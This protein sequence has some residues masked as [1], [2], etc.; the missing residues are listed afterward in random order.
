MV[1]LSRHSTNLY[2][3]NCNSFLICMSYEDEKGRKYNRYKWSNCRHPE[4]PLVLLSL[5]HFIEN[6]YKKRG[7]REIDEFFLILLVMEVRNFTMYFA[8]RRNPRK[9][10][11]I[12]IVCQFH[13]DKVYK[14]FS[15]KGTQMS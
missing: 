14:V 12:T 2:T 9:V 3:Y 4:E 11:A 6:N 13:C 5:L 15:E 8:N 7:R 10:V 1:N